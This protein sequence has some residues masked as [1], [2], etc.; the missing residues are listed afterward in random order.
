MSQDTNIAKIFIEYF[1]DKIYDGALESFQ[2]T[3]Y[4][5]FTPSENWA[6]LETYRKQ[7]SILMESATSPDKQMNRRRAGTRF[8][9]RQAR[10]FSHISNREIER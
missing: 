3:R 1:T 6:L 4:Y 2:Q 5:T 10:Y 9:P 8:K 7:P